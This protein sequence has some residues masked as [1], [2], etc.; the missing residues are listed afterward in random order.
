LA[1]VFLSGIEKIPTVYYTTLF[2]PQKLD[3]KTRQQLTLAYLPALTH[4]NG[5]RITAAEKEDADRA[6]IR[7]YMDRDEKPTR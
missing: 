5:G 3:E 4:L 1:K 7:R 2:V 6:F